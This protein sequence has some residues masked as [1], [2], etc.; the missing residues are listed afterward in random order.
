MEEKVEKIRRPDRVLG[1]EWEDWSGDLDESREYAET[2]RLFTL[3]AGI[4]FLSILFLLAF[5]LYMIE[6]RLRLIHP[7]LVYVARF[8]IAALILVSLCWGGLMV[9]SVF[10]GKNLILD[11][12]LGQ[13]SATRILPLALV[14]A[15]RLGISRDRLGSSFVSFSNAIVRVSHK[16]RQGKTI[17]LL[18]R[19]LKPEVKKEV[20][21]LAE[22]ADVKVFTVAGGGQARKVIQEQRP[23]AVIGVAC[24]RDLISGIHD[25]A[26]KLPTLGVANKRPEGPCKNT[27]IDI[28]ELKKAI[29]TLTGE[30]LGDET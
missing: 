22:R 24:E 21:E 30:T 14:I 12:R 10:T 27:L 4:A 2:A 5:T 3:Y 1:D 28:D 29:E 7:A 23:S 26:P 25:V 8:S 20:K 16:P 17:I 11:S 13:V 6:P 19:C 18:P 15:R 9:A